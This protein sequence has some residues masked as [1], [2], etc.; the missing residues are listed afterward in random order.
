MKFIMALFSPNRHLQAY[1]QIFI[2]LTKY[3]QL[4]FE[5]AK[6]EL[7]DR[8]LGQ[9]LSFFWVVAHPVIMMAIYVFVFSVVFK[10]KIGGTVELP[11]DYTAYLLSGLIPW[12]A[13]QESI[14]KAST[15]I[16]SH[17]NLVKQVVFPIEILPVKGVISSILTQMIFISVLVLYITLVEKVVSVMLLL[18]PIILLLQVILMIGLAYM[19]SAFG[20]YFKDTKDFVLVGCLAGI[21]MLPIFYLPSAVPALFSKVLFYNPISHLIWVYQDVFYFGK[22]AHMSSWWILTAMSLIVF[23]FGFR[24]FNRVKVMFGNVL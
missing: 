14:I 4:T 16:T 18:F 11:L 23:S 13:F 24:F 2:L 6:R 8:Y 3:R 5:M 1:K 21:Y 17:A 15:V 12:L 19:L 9:W 20:V 22:F 7:T 10:M